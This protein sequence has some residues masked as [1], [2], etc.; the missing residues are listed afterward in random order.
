[1]L[2]QVS[3]IL[4]IPSRVTAPTPAQP[5]TKPGC[6]TQPSISTGS[7]LG[8]R[9]YSEVATDE[10]QIVK[11]ALENGVVH[12]GYLRPYLDSRAIQC[13]WGTHQT[14]VAA[15]QLLKFVFITTKDRLTVG[16]TFTVREITKGTRYI[17]V[18]S[19]MAK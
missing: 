19:L 3:C 5:V 15:R 9:W 10:A 18:K 11:K 17:Y 4:E 2:S 13:L 14:V 6:R 1:L 12:Y 7:A 16:D 8:H